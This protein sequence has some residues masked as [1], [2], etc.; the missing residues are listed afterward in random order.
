MIEIKIKIEEKSKQENKTIKS[1]M[2]ELEIIETGKH[3]TEGE[4]KTS[5]IIKERLKVDQKIQIENLS[6]TKSKDEIVEEF[7]KAL[8]H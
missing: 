1:S 2:C 3:A 7:L 4:I 8:L 6:K 5:E